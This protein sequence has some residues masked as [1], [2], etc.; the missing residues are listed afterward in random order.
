MPVMLSEEAW[1]FWLDPSNTD[2]EAVTELLVP[3]PSEV[4]RMHPV[5]TDVNNVRNDGPHLIERLQ[6]Q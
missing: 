3:A 2:T 4:I 1:D 5:S 6:T